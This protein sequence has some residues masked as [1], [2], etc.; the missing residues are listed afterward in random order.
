MTQRT[1]I[2]TYALLDVGLNWWN[3]SLVASLNR[4]W[5]D[6]ESR[7]YDQ[8]QTSQSYD[9]NLP[10]GIRCSYYT[11]I[12]MAVIMSLFIQKVHLPMTLLQV[13]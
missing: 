4:L 12:T 6:G 11:S 13:T 9:L 3:V 5:P 8:F 1:L 7:S 10:Q 2:A